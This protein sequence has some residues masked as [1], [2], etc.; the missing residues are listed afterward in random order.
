MR[1]ILPASVVDASWLAEHYDAVVVADVRWYMDGR[2]GRA[3]YEA[4]HLPGAV[5]VDLDHDLSAPPTKEL[6]RHPLPSPQWVADRLGQLG[7]G[8]HDVVVA[9]DD[10]GGS[11]A[12]RL[13]WMLHV[14][15]QAV[16]VLDGGMASWH[17]PLET[18]AVHRAPVSRQ[19]RDWPVRRFV[20]A[21]RVDALRL[22][23]GAVVLDARSAVRYAE[24]DPAIDPRP[25]H[26]PG[27]RNAPW[28]E[29]LDPV[30]SRFRDAAWLRR[31][32]ETLGAD[33]AD[34]VVAYCGSGVTACHDLLAMDLAGITDTALFPGSWSAWG[35]DEDRPA[36][37]GSR[38]L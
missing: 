7:L 28:S 19:A 17:G 9:Y 37:T 6:G 31:R 12:A 22:D 35:G 13:W 33:E 20:D 5:F 24:G 8:D 34:V 36:A 11:I 38:P 16:A 29:N 10:A 2:S 27:A 32:F 15:G 3:A 26:I 30:D 1:S 25:G 14:L 4:G 18:V 21:D 23:P